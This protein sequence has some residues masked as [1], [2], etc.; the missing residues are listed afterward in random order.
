M[1]TEVRSTERGHGPWTVRGVLENARSLQKELS[2]TSSLN[3]E[4]LTSRT[5]REKI[6][7]VFKTPSLWRFVTAAIKKKKKKKNIC[8]RRQNFL[9]NS[10]A[11][12]A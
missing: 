12:P 9:L 2:L 10:L 6:S 5:H 8:S 1:E 7:V 4:L 3:F 11:I